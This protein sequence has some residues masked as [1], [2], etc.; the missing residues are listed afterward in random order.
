VSG[1]TGVNF[2]TMVT[3]SR[4]VDFHNRI[5]SM[6]TKNAS[7]QTLA[8]VGYS[9]DAGDR[10][11]QARRED[12]T[13]WNYGY[14]ARGEVTSGTRHAVGGTSIN[15]LERQYQYDAI[16]NRVWAKY[17]GGA[18]GSVSQI[19]Y[20]VNGHN[21]YTDID[22]PG[23]AWVVGRAPALD[24]VY[25]NTQL[26]D[27]QETWFSHELAASNSGGPVNLAVAV[28]D[29][30]GAP[31]SSGHLAVPKAEVSPT[32]DAAGNLA[33]DGRWV[34]EWDSVNRLRKMTA[35][36]AAT[37]AGFPAQVVEF[38]YDWQGKRIAKKVTEGSTIRHK[39]YLYEGW[40]VVA[41][42]T[43]HG[44]S[45][46][47]LTPQTYLWGLDLAGQSSGDVRQ[48]QSAGGVGG[49]LAAN[50][51]RTS[52]STALG[53][54]YTSYDG[55]GNILGW[56]GA[57]GAI[58]QSQDYDAFG[59]VV[60]RQTDPAGPLATGQGE[61]DYGFSTKPE[62][63][64]S[65][66]LYYGFR[67]YQPETGRWLSRD[68]IGERGGVNHYGFVK[69]NGVSRIDY[70]GL[71]LDDFIDD[72]G[73]LFEDESDE[74]NDIPNG[75][76]DGKSDFLHHYYHGNGADFDLF[77]R[78]Y[79]DRL[80]KAVDPVVIPSLEG[81]LGQISQGLCGSGIQRKT[82]TRASREAV[83]VEH[84][85]LTKVIFSFGDTTIV[86]NADE[87]LCVDCNKRT[88]TFDGKRFHSVDDRFTDPL[89]IDQATFGLWPGTGD[90]ARL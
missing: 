36:A 83:T 40:N 32:Y 7:G 51:I 14:N 65:R 70:L 10:R 11:T 18:T 9:Y 8:A 6:V 20:T 47:F 24:D 90:F 68:P 63:K 58:K 35:T 3:Q 86:S 77:Q 52:D 74:G 12:G 50:V 29:D 56:S 23:K 61:L 62:D 26:A 66:L 27:R 31:V 80:K 25:V 5:S 41:E 76:P 4:P 72:F 55:S 42:W 44:S 48:L 57:D 88:W 33:N 67:Y 81:K 17:G 49:L 22:H 85:D 15:G 13:Y 1:Y 45:T 38:V 78:G 2:G 69:N 28:T 87:K 82:I 79:G 64:E 54:L 60:L 89:N 46:T 30:L 73:D 59:N 75:G 16:G 34:Y 84:P 37:T 21:Q 19:D 71:F 39:R 53:N 43:L